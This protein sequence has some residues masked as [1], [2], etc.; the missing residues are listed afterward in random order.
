[1]NEI[2]GKGEYTWFDGS[3]Y[4]GAVKNG[5]RHGVGRYINPAEGVE[6]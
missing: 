5:M 6:Y 4:F 3:S 2:T 1:M